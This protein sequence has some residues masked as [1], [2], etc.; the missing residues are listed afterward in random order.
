MADIS[1]CKNHECKLKRTCYRYMAKPNAYRQAY[2]HPTPVD[3]QC[4][5]YWEYDK[6]EDT[7]GHK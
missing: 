4:D 1:M 5:F 7:D 6:K 3:G 2:I